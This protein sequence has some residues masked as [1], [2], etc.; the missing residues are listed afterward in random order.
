MASTTDM[1]VTAFGLC[2]RH[3]MDAERSILWE[4]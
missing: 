3:A 1:Q 2:L 4:D